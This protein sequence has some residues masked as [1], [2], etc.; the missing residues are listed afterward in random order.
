MIVATSADSTDSL[1]IKN[2]SIEQLKSYI[3]RQLG[4]PTWTLEITDQ[5]IL[6]AIN[7]ALMLHNQWRP[8]YAFR[9]IH[10]TT[11]MFSY[12]KGEDI[13]DGIIDVTFV[14][15]YPTPTEIFYGNLIDPAPILRSGLDE[16]DAW[17]RWQ[18][19]WKRVMSVTPDWYYDEADKVLYVHNPISRYQCTIFY[20][21]TVS[22]TEDLDSFGSRWVKEYALQRAKYTYGEIL[23]KFSGAIPGPVKDIQLDQSKRE[24]AQARIDALEEQLRG[25]QTSS[26]LTI[27]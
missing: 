1:P 10:L 17:M 19:T 7:D 26:P 16:Y 11:G 12:L 8:R 21:K 23:A 20:A 25:A 4:A 13:G 22:K 2:Y 5:H 18:K 27:D 3:K 9:T 6:D 14:E 24:Q 15:P